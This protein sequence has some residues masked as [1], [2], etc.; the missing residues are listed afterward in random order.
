MRVDV[1]EQQVEHGMDEAQYYH[2]LNQAQQ[3]YQTKINNQIN[4]KMSVK[5]AKVTE[6]VSINPWQSSNGTI[7]YC[8]C[9]MDNGDKISIG[10]KKEVQVGWDLTYEIVDTS[11]EYNK[12]KSAQKPEGSFTGGGNKYQDNTKGIKIGHAITNAVS[13]FVANGANGM[14][15]KD[16]IKNYAKLIYQ[17]SEE[18]N[19]E[20]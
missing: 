13:I 2:E 4:S 5:T 11:Q 15:D 12:A 10:K 16:A 6:V 1:Y 3:K 7:Y 17:I 9:V 8:N 20:L 14:S 18:L 19:N